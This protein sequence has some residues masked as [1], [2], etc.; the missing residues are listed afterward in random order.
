MVSEKIKETIRVKKEIKYKFLKL[1]FLVLL[2]TVIA[3]FID[4]IVHSLRPEFYVD[5]EYYR[6]KVI[7]S[8]LWGVVVLFVIKKIK[9]TK[10][11]NV[12][13][14]IFS[15]F[16]AVV[17]QVKYFLLGYDLFFVILFLFLH[18]FMFLIPAL[19]IFN[20]FKEI[21]G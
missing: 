6:N 2:I 4:W 10:N 18:F 21:F 3:T 14:L 15:A 9:L 1:V 5:F 20:K 13:A 12:K 17:L 11:I 16:I 19:I 7:F 8:V